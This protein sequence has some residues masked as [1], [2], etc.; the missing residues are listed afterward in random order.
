MQF[1]LNFSLCDSN[2]KRGKFCDVK[3]NDDDR[4]PKRNRLQGST[5]RRM[6]REKSGVKLKIV[7]QIQS[8]RQRQ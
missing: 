6:C 8:Y 2:Y 7:E 1:K 5:V 3:M 4:C